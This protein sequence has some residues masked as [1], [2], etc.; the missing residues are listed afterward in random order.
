LLT[1]TTPIERERFR[2]AAILEMLRVVREE[3]PQRPSARLSST[4]ARA[5]IAAVRGTEPAKLSR[6]FRGELDWIAMKALEK[7]RTRRYETA[8]GLARDIQRYLADEVVEARPPSTGYW[9]RKLVRRHKGQVIAAG[10]VLFALLV[11]ILGTTWGLFRAANA[12]AALAAK[13]HE[14]AGAS[15]DLSKLSQ[16]IGDQ[17]DAL[18]A[19]RQALA[20]DQKLADANPDVARFRENLATSH[21][22]LGDLLS[23]TGKPAEAEAE[24]RR[25]LALRQK[26]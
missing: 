4:E 26:L 14:L 5:S 7:D 24:L 12:N 15:L 11:G 8:N 18:I 19:I 10:L 3:E 23:D 2:T 13:I 9:L 17:Q 21:H 16:E 22:E 1:G 6:E 20:L 25:E